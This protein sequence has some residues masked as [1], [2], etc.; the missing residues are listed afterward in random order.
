MTRDPEMFRSLIIAPTVRK[1]EVLLQSYGRRQRIHITRQ[2]W[3]GVFVCETKVG[4][5]S[6]TWEKKIAFCAA[7]GCEGKGDNRAQ[8]LVSTEKQ[9][10]C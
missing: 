1:K 5:T 7:R 2:G 4:D 8:R 9:I 3:A 10:Q 6:G